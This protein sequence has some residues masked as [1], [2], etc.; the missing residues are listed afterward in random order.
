MSAAHG[1]P[2]WIPEF[3]RLGDQD[4]QVEFLSAVLPWLD[5]DEQSQIERYAYFMAAD[6]FLLSLEEEEG[7]NSGRL[8]KVGE[9]Y[10][11]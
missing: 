3:Q 9:I 8:S 6:G 10:V 5:A 4:G 7:D 2:I 1:K 11:S